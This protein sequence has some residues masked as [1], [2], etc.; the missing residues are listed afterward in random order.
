VSVGTVN[1]L[2]V[3]DAH[4]YWEFNPGTDWVFPAY[5]L[6]FTGVGFPGPF[7]DTPPGGFSSVVPG[8]R[9][10]GDT[11][12]PSK[13]LSSH[14]S[15]IRPENVLVTDIALP[16]SK[17]RIVSANEPNSESSR[18][19]AELCRSLRIFEANPFVGKME[20]VSGFCHAR[21]AIFVVS[22]SSI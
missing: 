2:Q 13:H 10:D 18:E 20:N 16:W 17:S 3:N 12:S 6:P 14:N 5:E 11:E 4:A 21:P 7:K 19:S 15:I 8:P 22:F 1:G 9:P